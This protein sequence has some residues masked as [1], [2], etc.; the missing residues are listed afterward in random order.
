[1]T[2]EQLLVTAEKMERTLEVFRQDG[3][4]RVSRNAADSFKAI[5]EASGIK[6]FAFNYDVRTLK[7]ELNMDETELDEDGIKYFWEREAE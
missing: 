4:V 3:Y 7:I 5:L 6:Y 2:K 1:M